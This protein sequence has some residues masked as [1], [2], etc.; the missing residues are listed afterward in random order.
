MID[1]FINEF[2]LYSE[3][4][5]HQLLAQ[6]LSL[7]LFFAFSPTHSAIRHVCKL[8]LGKTTDFINLVKVWYVTFSLM[9]SMQR[10]AQMIDTEDQ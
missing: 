8:N 6:S 5:I 4:L 9:Q 2:N 1:T 3:Q 10:T 7:S